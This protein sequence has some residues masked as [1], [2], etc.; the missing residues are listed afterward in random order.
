MQASENFGRATQLF[1]AAERINVIGHI[2]PDADAIGSVCSVIL[3]ARQ[4]GKTAQG[5]IGQPEDFAANL[6]TIP[7]ADSVSASTTLAEAD[8]VVVVDCGSISR[9]G[10]F[11]TALAESSM[12]M[13]V[14]DH[15]DSNRGFGTVDL[16]D[17]AAESTTTVLWQWFAD[18]GI[19]ID[20]PLAHAL[21]AGL[22]TDTGSFRWGS[23]R[24]HAMAADL[25][26]HGIDTRQIAAELIDNSTLA[27]MK[28][29]GAALGRIE[30]QPVGGRR[31]AVLYA[32]NDEI[33]GLD[34]SE[35]ESL[36]DF[37]RGVDGADV[38]VVFKEYEPD[39]HAVSLRAIADI[40]VSVIAARLGGGGHLRAAG[41]TCAGSR[42]ENLRALKDVLLTMEN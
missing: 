34:T 30:V 19:A 26:Q 16:I 20:Q 33:A 40:D 37:V 13:I 39:W 18:M 15:H 23:S 41:Y 2:R 32:R 42:E 11:K 27:G 10:I 38:G 29:L 36:V 8:L 35:V 22:V 12:P 3:A 7:G 24:M 6:R 14:V 17:H 4:L 5:F 31:L 21:Y 9:T 1:R 28:M 25:V